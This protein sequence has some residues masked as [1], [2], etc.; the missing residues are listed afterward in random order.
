MW[1]YTGD[2]ASSDRDAVRFEIQDT[3]ESNPLLQDPEIEYALAQETGVLG[4][5]ARCCEALARRFA[6]RADTVVGSLTETYSAMAAVYA[7][8]AKELRIRSSTGAPWAGGLTRTDKDNR[9]QDTDR[10]QGAFARGQFNQPGGLIEG[11][12]NDP[13]GLDG[14][15]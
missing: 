6:S 2:P 14:W 8:R 10:T 5:A 9:R 1:T 13:D 15:V 11:E 7:D 3:D 4:A 12:V